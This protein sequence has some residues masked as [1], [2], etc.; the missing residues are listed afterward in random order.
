MFTRVLR[1]LSSWVYLWKCALKSIFL[2]Q[3]SFWYHLC[4]WLYLVYSCTCCLYPAPKSFISNVESR[5]N[6]KQNYIALKGSS[7]DISH[8]TNVNC[9]VL[10]EYLFFEQ[11]FHEVFSNEYYFNNCFRTIIFRTNVFRTNFR[12]A[13]IYIRRVHASKTARDGD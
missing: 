13:D 10:F 8:T 11:L 4:I 1:N 5:F 12:D 6:K 7:L 3:N 2:T 9:D